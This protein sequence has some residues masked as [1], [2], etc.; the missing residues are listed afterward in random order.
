[1]GYEVTLIRTEEE[2]ARFAPEWQA[3]L[4]E[5][6]LGRHVENDPANVALALAGMDRAEPR[7]V[8]LRRQGA[9]CCI[10]PCYL[11]R[12]R[13]PLRLSVLNL[14]ALP[15]RMMK[16]FGGQFLRRE[17]EDARKCFDAVFAELWKERGQFG[18]IHFSVLLQGGDLWSYLTEGSSRGRRFRLIRASAQGEKVHQIRLPATHDQYMAS[19]GPKTRQN[20]RRTTRRF[21][22]GGVTR[23][24]RYSA[25]EQ[26]PAFLALLDEVGPRTWQ[27]KTFGYHPRNTESHRRHFEQAARHGW[28][29]SYVLTRDDRPVAFELGYQYAGTYYGFECGY[30]QDWA[31]EGPGSVLMHLVIEDLYKDD[32]P[33][34]LDFGFG[35]AAYKRSFGNTEYEAC[36]AHL[37]PANRWRWLLLVQTGLDAVE[38][39]VRAAL[40]K[41]HLDRPVRRLLKRQRLSL[42]KG[43][44]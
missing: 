41:A 28:L 3:F 16:V 44:Q 26:V 8:V 1:M 29:R 9:V 17:S 12:T 42:N 40:V 43:P 24:D 22:E 10:A 23:L 27:A 18:L 4:S 38:A 13:L 19:L 5:P 36:S 37:V 15:V 7:V 2:L 34:L 33:D 14:G 11:H 21:F 39:N 30:D 32:R 6:V 35:D 31:G 20:L 25:P